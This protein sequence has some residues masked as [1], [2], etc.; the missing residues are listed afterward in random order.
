MKKLVVLAG[1]FIALTAAVF[2]QNDLQAL[3]VVKL[4][5]SETITVRTLKSRAG[6]VLKQYEPYGITELSPEQRQKILENLIDEKLINQAAVKEGLSVTDSEV[7]AS[8]LDTFSQQLGQQV[9][10]SQLSD[11]IK[12][13][14]GKS[15]DEY[16]KENSGMTMS[17]YK[18]YLRSQLL[19]QKYVYAKK[20]SELARVA[21]ADEE[22]RKAY[23]L[24]KAT[25]VWNDMM[26]LFLVM[27]PKG[28][29]E[30]QARAKATDLKNQYEKDKNVAKK[31]KEDAENG[32]VY[33]AGELLVAKTSQQAVQLGWNYDKI[34]ELFGNNAGYVSDITE[35]NT[36]FQFYAIIKK[37]DA[38]ML[39][40]SDPVQPE[41]NVTVYEYI[42]N[43]LT[44]QK[45]TQFFA[46]AAQKLADSLDTPA[47]V[48]RKKTGDDLI[49]LLSW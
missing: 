16:L 18:S 43:N 3:A 7:N 28:T 39:S 45:Q 9:T 10:E 19:T 30:T 12:K 46:D 23:D 8:F 11:L 35:T 6:F 41:S 42:K 32:K 47:N 37:Y 2:A 15:L 33:R 40:I 44:R 29:D 5:K 31:I 36:D 1:M 17:E 48:E 13:Q 20:Q 25:F 34:I 27:V 21:A 24:N 26:K 22:I 4:N 38:K 14:T 49:K